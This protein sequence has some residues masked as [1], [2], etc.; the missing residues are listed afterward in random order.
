MNIQT[1]YDLTQSLCPKIGS[2]VTLAGK[3]SSHLFGLLRL[4]VK[5]CNSTVDP[6]CANDTVYAAYEAAFGKFDMM[7]AFVSTI[8]NPGKQEYKSYY[9]D[10]LTVFRF[11]SKLGIYSHGS[12]E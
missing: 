11:D 5:R 6:T 4:T 2:E 10:T 12:I 3:L 1:N 7:I 9:L 8:V